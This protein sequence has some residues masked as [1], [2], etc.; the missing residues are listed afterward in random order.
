M[1]MCV[2]NDFVCQFNE[3]KEQFFYKREEESL[4]HRI[5][6]RSNDKWLES[7]ERAEFYRS[8]MTR[9]CYEKDID[10]CSG[11]KVSGDIYTLLGFRQCWITQPVAE[12]TRT[13]KRRI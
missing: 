9:S 6:S 8:S 3:D 4:Y 10:L 13:R 1:R 2:V 12:H 7:V 11:Y 5:I